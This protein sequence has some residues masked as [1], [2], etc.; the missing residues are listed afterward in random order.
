[1]TE[2]DRQLCFQILDEDDP[3]VCAALIGAYYH[4]L[5]RAERTLAHPAYLWLHIGMLA[6]CVARLNQLLHS[7]TI[8]H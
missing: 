8:S 2:D 5:D 3:V 4:D 7:P 6:G 1:M